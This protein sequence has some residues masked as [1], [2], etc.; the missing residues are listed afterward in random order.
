MKDFT[1]TAPDQLPRTEW[2]TYDRLFSLFEP[3]APGN[4]NK[5]GRSNLKQLII[6][7]YKDDPAFRGEDNAAINWKLW[8][9][10]FNDGNPATG[11]SVKAC[12]FSF[13]YTPAAA[14]AIGN[15]GATEEQ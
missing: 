14:E 4:I 12:W 5:Q 1:P 9:R 8:C 15:G 7:W 6:E 10:R 13:R 11:R 3:R 2:A